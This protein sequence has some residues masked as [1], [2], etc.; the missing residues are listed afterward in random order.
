MDKLDH[1]SIVD[2]CLL[3]GS[4]WRTYRHNDM[5]HL[6]SLLSSSAGKY[7][8]VLVIADSVFSMDGD[9]MDLPATRALC[10][11]FGARLMVDEAHSIGA[12]GAT[13][14]GIEEHF[15]MVGSID[16]KMG[17]LS[18]SI[19]SV[20]GYCAA[21]HEIVDY[22]RHMSRPFIFSA[23]LP[24]A[25]TAAAI[26]AFD[27][28]DDEPWRVERL[29]VMQEAY[30]TGLRTQGWDT[31]LASTCVVPVLVGDEE[32]TMDLTRMLFDRGIFVC[33]IV[34][35]AVPRGTER[36]RTCLMAT[37]TEEDVAQVLDAFRESGSAL[38]LI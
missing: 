27:V 35:P 34:H 25:Q 3:S 10:D 28:I 17:T 2:G 24:P 4:K 19:P 23:A 11:R 22:L 13:G 26:A 7:G 9:I 8:T 20:G 6:E 32:K 14:H 29:H 18:K 12:L 31:M 37:H 1:A 16:L 5:E 38:G 30:A 21:T 15:G 36:L 33:P